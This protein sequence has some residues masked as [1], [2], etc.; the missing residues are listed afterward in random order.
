MI[1]IIPN[2]HPIFV[3][4]T[5]GLFSASV[6][7]FILNYMTTHLRM[8]SLSL[9]TEFE[10]AG[11]W[12]LWATGLAVIATVA[13]GLYAYYTVGHD[14]ASHVAMTIHRNWALPTACAILVMVTWSLWRYFK[15][16]N[17]S[18]IFIIALLIVQGL[19]LSTAWHGAEVVYRYGIGVISLPKSEGVGHNHHHEEM[20]QDTVTNSMPDMQEE[21]SQDAHQHDHE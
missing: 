2:W 11:R 21:S 7:F 9:T 19:L 16:K 10:I 1:Q 4:F 15:Q 18:F 3:H 17:P 20:M 6:G 12:C 13:A 5:I 14:A 8:I